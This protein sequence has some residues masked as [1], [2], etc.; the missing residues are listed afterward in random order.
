MNR[1]YISTI[2]FALF[3]VLFAFSKSRTAEHHPAILTQEDETEIINKTLDS[4]NLAAAKADFNSYFNFYMPDAIFTGTDATERWNK[5]EF[6]AFAKPYFD[7]GRA[8]SYTSLERHIYFDETGKLA[9][10]DEL[11]NTQM[12]ICR[13]SGVMVKQPNGWKLKQYILSTTVPND[14]MNEL[15]QKKAAAEDVIIEKFKAKN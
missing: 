8:W 12:K 9:W 3:F 14:L 11:V 4:F 2:L 15:V 6:M 13:G 5:D 1:Y 10:F 7:R